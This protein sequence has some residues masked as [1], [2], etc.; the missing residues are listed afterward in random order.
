[1]VKNILEKINDFYEYEMDVR[2]E[3]DPEWIFGKIALV[4]V[5][6]YETMAGGEEALP[7]TRE[8]I[9]TY[10]TVVKKPPVVIAMLGNSWETQIHLT[11]NKLKTKAVRRAIELWSHKILPTQLKELL[12]SKSE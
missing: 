8:L 4:E 5:R 6:L 3:Q 11:E 7:A 1:M 10:S 2:I 9:H 12:D